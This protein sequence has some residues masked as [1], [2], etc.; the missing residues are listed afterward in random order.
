M[1]EIAPSILSVD[2]SRLAEQVETV[3][4]AGVKMLHVDVMDGQFVPNISLG[5]PVIKSLHAA[6]DLFLDCHLMIADPDRYV[7]DFV[8]AGAQLVSVH[9]EACAHLHRSIQL[10]HDQGVQA[11]VVINPAT[12][13]HT[14]DEILPAVDLV[15][16][17][18]VNPGFGGQKFLPLAFE[19]VRRLREIRAERALHY[20]IEVDGGVTL[21]NAGDLVEAGADILVAGSSIFGTP[22]PARAV[23]C[24]RETVAQRQLVRV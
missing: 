7:A 18:S 11:G 2:F 1:A 9:Q 16:V 10:V 14:L 15:L 3:Q 12:P 6:T 13:V 4:R 19:K 23:E 5:P 24:F 17:M 22:D 21:D 8:A 20:K